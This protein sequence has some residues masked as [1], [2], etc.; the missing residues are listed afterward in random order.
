M[1]GAF[2][3]TRLQDGIFQIEDELENCCTLVVGSERALLFDTMCG[4][5]NLRRTVESLTDLPLT[6][7]NSHGHYDHV[8][9]N[10]QFEQV[11]LNKADWYMAEEA[12]PIFN[13]LQTNLNRDL[14]NARRS[15]QQ[16]ERLLDLKEG[17]VFDLG[18]ITAQ[19]VALPGHTAGSMGLILREPEILLVGDAISPTMCLFYPD[20]LSLEVYKK[21]LD[22]VI[23]M[24]LRYFVQGHYSKLFPMSILARFRECAL[25]PGKKKSYPYQNSQIPVY[26]GRVY[27]LEL[28]NQQIDSMICLIDK[29]E[30]RD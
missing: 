29:E 9:G 10:W 25:L 30:P 28:R 15:F 27:I 24:N 2:K 16:K 5:G 11:Y 23:S 3:I 20:S 18:G 8:G 21:T 12:E 19:T 1:D 14:S 4:V 7:V 22:K 6:V 17:T 26:T 13:M